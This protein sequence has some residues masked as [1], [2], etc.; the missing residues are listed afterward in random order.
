MDDL[1]IALF[2]RMSER[3]LARLKDA[4]ASERP[5]RAIWAIS[6]HSTDTRLI[7][8]FMALANRIEGLK[9]E[10]IHFIE[11][12]RALEVQVLADALA[13]VP[14]I[15]HMGA[16]G[17]AVTITSLALLLSRENQLGVTSGHAEVMAALSAFLDELEPLGSATG[18]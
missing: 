6:L 3:E 7:S 12:A 18:K 8:E 16:P 17:L 14:P 10:V 13:R 9:L 1:V 11:E 2:R 15:S 4:A 5:L